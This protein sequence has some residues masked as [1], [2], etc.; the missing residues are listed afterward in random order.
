MEMVAAPVVQRVAGK[1]GDI[2]WEK[3][4]LLWNFKEDVQDIEGKMVDLQV[5]VSF[6]DKHSRGTEDSPVQH[7]LKKYKFVAYDMEDALDELEADAMI[8]K[9]SPSKIR[10]V[11]TRRNSLRCY[12]LPQQAKTITK[13][14]EKRLLVKEM[15]LRW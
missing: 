13:G 8:W 12:C 7:W 2:A 5:A 15:K 10:L 9:H 6:A 11:R 1:L 14:R 4:Q 3:L